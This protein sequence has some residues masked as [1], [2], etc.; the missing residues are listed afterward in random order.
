MGR[1]DQGNKAPTPVGYSHGNGVSTGGPVTAVTGVI[2][3]VE[4]QGRQESG[5]AGR[6]ARGAATPLVL[7]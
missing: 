4:L 5:L 3:R 1:P 7:K 2:A 6:T